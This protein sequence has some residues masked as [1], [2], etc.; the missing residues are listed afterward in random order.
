MGKAPSKRMGATTEA[1]GMSMGTTT[2][3]EGREGSRRKRWSL[4]LRLP[5]SIHPKEPAL[6]DYILS[7]GHIRCPRTC[8]RSSTHGVAP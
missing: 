7:L 2:V 5:I 3:E 8:I 4:E 1:L 6:L